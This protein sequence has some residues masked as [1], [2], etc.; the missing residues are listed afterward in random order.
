MTDRMDIPWP[1]PVEWF[2]QFPAWLDDTMGNNVV[3][4]GPEAGRVAI[5]FD[6]ED[7]VVAHVPDFVS[8]TIDGND[9]EFYANTERIG[10]GTE[11]HHGTSIIYPDGRKVR[12]GAIPMTHTDFTDAHGRPLPLAAARKQ[13]KAN[14]DDPRLQRA[15]GRLVDRWVPRPDG[16][17]KRL[18][19]FLGSLIPGITRDEAIQV[20]TAAVSGEWVPDPLRP[21]QFQHWGP[22]FVVKGAQRP[23]AAAHA[24]VYADDDCG[25]SVAVY[26]SGAVVCVDGTCHLV[27]PVEAAMTDMPVQLETQPAEATSQTMASAAEVSALG[28]QVATLSDAVDTLTNLVSE[29]RE[30]LDERMAAVEMQLK[31]AEL[32]EMSAA[33]AIDVAAALEQMQAQIDR[34][35]AQG[36]ASSSG[37][38]TPAVL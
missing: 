38:F 2:E 27:E 10:I 22:S 37:E 20:S 31:K 18:G 6:D 34:L 28:A 24:H 9:A 36:E 15:V 14:S 29:I 26:D 1:P 32:E 23:V 5:V 12:V 4:D 35:T 8:P 11:A 16:T 25:P 30:A 13:R 17:M 33:E 21:G 19:V 7:S 3:L